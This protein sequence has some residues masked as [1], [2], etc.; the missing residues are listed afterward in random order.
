VNLENPGENVVESL[1]HSRFTAYRLPVYSK[2]KA[3]PKAALKIEQ[4]D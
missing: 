2:K 3:A 1:L 4:P